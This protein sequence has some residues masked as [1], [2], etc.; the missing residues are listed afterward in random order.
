[1]EHTRHRAQDTSQF[2]RYLD[3]LGKGVD[4]DLGFFGPDT[5]FWRV[6]REPALLLVGMR[7][8]LMQIAH[9]KVAQGVADHSRY[10]EAPLDRGIRTFMAVYTIAFGTRPETIEAAL[11]VRAVHDRVHGQV[12]DPLP[13]GMDSTYDASDPE[14]QLWVAA[15]LLDSAV[16]AYELFVE[17]LSAAEKERHY[18]EGRMFGQLFGVPASLYPPTWP[19]F[20]RWLTAMLASDTLTVTPTARAIYDGLLTGT[21]FARLLAPINRVM[22]ATLC[23]PPLAVGFGLH[24]SPL[25]RAGYR[26]V[27]SLT[28]LGVRLCPRHLRGVPAARRSERRLKRLGILGR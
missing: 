9:P 24:Q 6:S 21:L 17:P 20:Q 2:R 8:L 15:T 27:V 5:V 16:V 28:R 19:D 13:A 3:E 1:V 14:L 12:R 22:A 23:P 18:Q 11:A 4:P 10:R 26:V 7:A 25:I